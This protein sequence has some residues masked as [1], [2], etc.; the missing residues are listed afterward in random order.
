MLK[1]VYP[2][3]VSGENSGERPPNNLGRKAHINSNLISLHHQQYV[4]VC[5]IETIIE[6]C[7]RSLVVI[8]NEKGEIR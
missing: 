5:C 1:A 4:H 3:Q 6:M 2:Y 8:T 7:L